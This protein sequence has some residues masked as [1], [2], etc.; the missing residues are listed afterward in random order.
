MKHLRSLAA[1]GLVAGATA[2]APH[3]ASG[4]PPDDTALSESPPSSSPDTSPPDDD[5][6]TDPSDPPGSAEPAPSA[7]FTEGDCPAEVDPGVTVS[8]GVI[9]TPLN[10]EDPAGGTIQLAVA[11]IPATDGSTGN[12]PVVVL[13]GGPGEPLVVPILEALTPDGAFLTGLGASRDIV[14]L[15]QRG[16]GASTPSLACPEFDEALAAVTDSDEAVAIGTEALSACHERLVAEGVDLSAFDTAADVQDLDVARQAL[17][18]E[19]VSLFGTSYGA[20]LALQ[21]ARAYPETVESAALSSPVPAE[22]NF[23]ADAAVSV[24]SAVIALG[25]ACA[26]DEECNANYPDVAGTALALVEQF[27]AEPAMVDI[28]DPATGE[29][30]TVPIDGGA[31]AS[32]LFFQFYSPEGAMLFP[33]L[34]TTLT[35]GDTSFLSTLLVQPAPAMNTGQMLSFLCADEATNASPEDQVPGELG[36]AARA[37]EVNAVVGPNLWSLCEIW[38][39]EP[40]APETFEPVS[41]DV[42]LLVVTGQFDHVTPPAYG[43]AVADDSS[44]AWYVEVAGVG[45]SPLFAAGEC[46][47][48]V[49]D[50]FVSAPT[51]QPDVSCVPTT[52]TFLTPEEI[53]AAAEEGGPGSSTPG[54]TP[55]SSVPD[56]SAPANSD[57]DG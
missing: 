39:V 52:P 38:D 43:E 57:P 13:G 46:G 50:A 21:V 12:T 25:E 31:L 36:L 20:R 28:T 53:A 2:L 16:A 11:V 22:E 14:L 18:Y 17:G 3:A 40:G 4:S 41:T 24:D 37:L 51:V 49:L 30:I 9:D 26:A 7:V 10:H 35:D 33:Y 6:T 1:A 19:R 48:A 47:L 29:M 34:V 32:V 56:S 45:H 8:C 15:D 27:D 55:N 44:T 23:V 42:P 5:A 54:S